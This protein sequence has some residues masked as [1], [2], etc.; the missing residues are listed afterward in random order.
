MTKWIGWVVYVLWGLLC[1][2][3]FFQFLFPYDALSRRIFHTIEQK[4]ALVARP[5]DPKKR[6]LGIRW[7]R[8]E[9]VSPKYKTLPAIRIDKC[10]IQ[11][12]PIS[13][14][15]GQLSVRSHG[16]VLGGTFE[17][18]LSV[19]RNRRHGIGVWKN[20][21]MDR[22]PILMSEGVS[23]SGMT[24]GEVAW[25]TDGQQRLGEASFELREGKI[26]NLS[27]AGSSLPSIDLGTIRGQV[28]LKAETIELKDISVE[29]GDL[30]GKL[31]GT[32]SLGNPLIRSR[33]ACRLEIEVGENL[34][35]SY[36]IIGAFLR[37]E[38][39]QSEPLVMTVGGTLEAPRISPAR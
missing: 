21:R 31:S 30:R 5:S 2:F 1:F 27:I 39:G 19:E 25:E 17:T 11:L 26:E 3:V 20:V 10:S 14:L 28:S 7:D 6:L 36:P 33:V 24:L 9:V 37:N 29:G 38:Q 13:L 8:V 32:I 4:T 18:T 16:D 35:N 34:I 22:F 15:I 12:R 23:L